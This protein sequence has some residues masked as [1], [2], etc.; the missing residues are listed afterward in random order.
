MYKTQS[1]AFVYKLTTYMLV[2]ETILKFAQYYKLKV[3]HKHI[4]K[5]K[6]IPIMQLQ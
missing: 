4:H 1:N 5:N 2:L 3:P 6:K